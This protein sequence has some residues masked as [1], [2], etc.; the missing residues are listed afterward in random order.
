LGGVLVDRLSRKRVIIIADLGQT[1]AT[2]LLILFFWLNIASIYLVLGIVL[3]RGV[4]QAF[5]MPAVNAIVPSMVPQDKLSRVN[6]LEY[7]F[8]GIVQV[9]GPIIAALLLTYVSIDQLLWIDPIT[10]VAGLSVLLLVRIPFVR[11]VSG[12]S[13]FRQ[14]FAEGFSYLRK[15]AGFIP[16]IF[17]AVALNFLITPFSTLLPYF[18]K[19]DHF[20]GAPDWAFVQASLQGGFIGGGLFMLLSK[21]FRRKVLASIVSLLVGLVGYALVS[22]TPTG[23]FWF[24]AIAVLIFAV[25]I[26]V[27]N[28][29]VRTI[30][31]TYAPL[32]IQG[33]IASVVISLASIATPV[34]MI[35][36][37]IIASYI[38][39][40]TLF[41]ACA[42]VG[43]VVTV[44]CWFFTSV[45]NLEKIPGIQDSQIDASV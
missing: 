30:M 13:S 39:T 42:I 5:H 34:S 43:I 41:L 1:I 33:R 16:L 25:P 4:F 31:Q 38:G 15:T 19:F 44:L 3:I 2:I 6:S 37:G 32:E 35:L 14:D 45:R 28:I 22:V 11:N 18:V 7:V 17:L 26:P 20:G 12:R 40:S 36:S 27:T 8:N 9:S 23:L 10:Y 21:G 29:L 24:M